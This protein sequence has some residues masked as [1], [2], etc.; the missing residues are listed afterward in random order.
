M[1]VENVKRTLLV[2]ASGKSST[3]KEKNECR[4]ILA[5]LKGS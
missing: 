2:L 5:N 4:V 3:T 1:N